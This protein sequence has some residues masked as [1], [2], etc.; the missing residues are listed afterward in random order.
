MRVCETRR[1]DLDVL[2]MAEERAVM[3]SMIPLFN[4]FMR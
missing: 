3:R 2:M 4:P 1:D